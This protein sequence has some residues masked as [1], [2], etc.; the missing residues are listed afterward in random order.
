MKTTRKFYALL[1][2]F[3]LLLT[4]FQLAGL[5]A[6]AADGDTGVAGEFQYTVLDEE[7]K[8][9]A[10]TKYTGQMLYLYIPEELNGY[11][12]VEIGDSAF[13]GAFSIIEVEIPY[14][15]THIGNTVFTDCIALEA[16][17]V[18]KDNPAYISQDGIL[19]NKDKTE[20]IRYP[21][22]K[23]GESYNIPDSV[24]AI[25]DDAFRGCDRLKDISI[26]SGLERIG[27]GAFILCYSLDSVHIPESV[28]EIGPEAFT[29]C[30][31]LREFEV[32]Q[33][34]AF[35][36]SQDGV[37]FNKDKTVLIRYPEAKAD[38]TYCI[39]E[40]VIIVEA[41]AF[42]GNQ[43][44]STVTIPDG[45]TT[46][47]ASAFHGDDALTSIVLPESVTDLGA[48]AFF[49]CRALTSV[50]ISNGITAL[51]VSTFG[52]CTSLTGIRL[53][54]HLQSIGERTFDGC[55][56]LKHV[57]V[58]NT[59]KSIGDFA[60]ENCDALTSIVI[61]QS[62][63]DLGHEIFFYCEAQ[64]IYGFTGSAAQAYA[65]Q[66]NIP[67]VDVGSLSDSPAYSVS[68]LADGDKVTVTV[69]LSGNANAADGDFALQYDNSKLDFVTTR[70]KADWVSVEPRAQENAVYL[71]FSNAP[72][73]AEDT[74]LWEI[75]FRRTGSATIGAEDFSVLDYAIFNAS[76]ELTAYG[77]SASAPILFSCTHAQTAE[78]IRKQ[79][80]HAEPG[81]AAT[82]CT[83]CGET[84]KTNSIPKLEST[85][86]PA[87]DI[88]DNTKPNSETP[89]PVPEIPKTGDTQI[90]SNVGAL[91]VLCAVTGRLLYA[92]N[93]KRKD[94]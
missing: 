3:P 54:N 39:P 30:S 14:T 9:C 64:T 11:T 93:K 77:D 31:L 57:T 40:S 52:R 27:A 60:F 1:L 7:K 53:P 82:V 65:D 48:Y 62:V 23:E 73:I 51:E 43:F 71:N 75:E 61:P 67:F 90:F 34:N 26:P 33:G 70:A 80:T 66:Y 89:V 41:S 50:T 78:E 91:F 20:L 79:P 25:A 85:N 2:T 92:E 76:S 47:G 42:S 6:F 38:Q 55:R 35:Y 59:V 5:T 18:A 28:T 37:L 22:E 17:Q 68:V 69:S 8:T 88:P 44:L 58:P 94:N 32:A 83:I 86:T 74:V 15:V 24:T 49:G 4:V 46:L 12:V 56:A 84:L 29:T 36:T 87:T 81:E 16:I 21:E 45:V 13:F 19:F 72:A 63:T 10:I